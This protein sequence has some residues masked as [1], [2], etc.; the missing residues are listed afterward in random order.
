MGVIYIII[1]ALG[2]AFMDFFVRLSGDLPFVQKVFFRNI[3]ALVI[4]F[5]ILIKESHPKVTDK[6]SWALMVLRSLCGTIGIF[7]NFYAIDHLVLSDASILNKLSPFCTLLFSWWFL[8]EKISP[9][10]LLLVIGAF[11][12]SLFIIKPTGFG[13]A[14]FLPSLVGLLGGIGAGAAYT[15][16]RALG[17]RNVNG[18]LIVFVFSLISSLISLP[19]FIH[20]G[21]PMS[22]GQLVC[23]LCAGLAATVGQF[24]ITTA[25]RYAPSREISIYDYTNVVF[26]AILGYLFF[27][28]VPDFW[29]FTGYMVIFA[30]ALLMFFYTKRHDDQ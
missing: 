12:G 11:V 29:S 22:R 25:Y 14:T 8:K 23:L 16:V 27:A 20:Y 28:Q 6:S 9:V 13:N 19:F 7:G 5:P 3:V 21:I 17:K 2:F 10:R 24:G 15:C 4:V 30:M 18:T 26:T 1:S